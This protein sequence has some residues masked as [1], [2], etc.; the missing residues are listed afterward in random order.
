MTDE[1][2]ASASKAVVN[3]R[4]IEAAMDCKPEIDTLGAFRECLT[5]GNHGTAGS[6]NAMST[7]PPTQTERLVA[8]VERVA[9]ERKAEQA[10]QP[11]DLLTPQQRREAAAE[12]RER[13]ARIEAGR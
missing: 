11:D 12:Y 3:R 2:Q 10:R 1:V 5:G 4:R 8:V 9:A 6:Y 13:A 7:P